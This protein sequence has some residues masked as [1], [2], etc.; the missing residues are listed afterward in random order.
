[1]EVFILRISNS[2]LIKRYTTS[3]TNSL[4]DFTTA[5][6][7]ANTGRAYTR[8]SEDTSKAVVAMQ[9]RREL[10]RIDGYKSNILSATSHLENAEDLMMD[11]HELY[12]EAYTNT[13]QGKNGTYDENQRKIIANSL[14]GLQDSMLK[15]LNSKSAEKYVFSG[16]T[17]QNKPYS[18]DADGYLVFAGSDVKD[19]LYLDIGLGVKIDAAT[20]KPDPSSVLEYTVNGQEFL[21]VATNEDGTPNQDNVFNIMTNLIKEFNKPN[22]SYNQDTMNDLL[23]KLE[24]SDSSILASITNIGSRTS[25]IKFNSNRIDSNQLTLK[26]KQNNVES[27]DL[28]EAFM[29]VQ[30]FE[31]AYRATLQ[32]GNKLIQP[33]F[34]DFMK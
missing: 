8:V 5:S 14:S 20:G 2:M 7:K 33:S 19:K 16:A 17:T 6:N 25:Y 27:V 29:D 26:E 12:K 13:L 11:F 32:M 22:G 30:A 28:A 21:G 9:T 24:G 34:I 18:T 3:L 1:M 10:K 31:L 15:I 4:S 23:N